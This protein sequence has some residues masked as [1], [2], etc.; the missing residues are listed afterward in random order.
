MRWFHPPSAVLPLLF[1]LSLASQVDAAVLTVAWDAPV[2]NNTAGYTVFYG[3]APGVYTSQINAGFVTQRVI[4]GLA[5]GVTYYFAVQAY[6]STGEFSDLSTVA[7]GTAPTTTTT[8]TTTGGSTTKGKGG[9]G[10][11]K[12][13]KG[14][15]AAAINDDQH[16]EIA[17]E[18]VS[19]DLPIGAAINVSVGYRVEVGTSPG[20][21]SYSALTTDHGVVFDMTDMPAETYFIRIRPVIG[22]T[23]GVSYGYASDEIE[24]RPER[25]VWPSAPAN[26]GVAAHCAA[27]PKAP[28][29]LIAA[30]Q[31]S[32]V[33]LNWTPGSGEL[34][35]GFVLHVGTSPGLQDVLTTDFP[36]SVSG[37]SAM[38]SNAAYALR[39]SAVNECGSSVWAP[40]TMLYVGVAP[41]PGMPK[42]LTP[43]VSGGLVT[44]TWEPPSTGGPSTRYLLE[45]ATPGGPF[46]H[47]TGSQ[48]TVFANANT[49]PGRYIVTVRAGNATGFGPASAPM[50]LVVR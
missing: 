33:S 32:A 3:T 18:P 37:V 24:V 41:L 15:P 45:A 47:D 10:N 49:P 5:D 13:S 1:A 27:P 31:G 46:V 8:T 39:L 17:W 42:A 2:D 19:A 38:A 50:T 7:V 35:V 21:T 6:S 36:G 43:E 20:D 14:K 23:P 26:A 12:P 44:L 16:I 22:T 34:P 25:P 4:D 48:G 40:E 30:A 9:S 29:Q 11:T 28:R